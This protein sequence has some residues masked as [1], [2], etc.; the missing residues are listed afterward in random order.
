MSQKKHWDWDDHWDV[1]NRIWCVKK[2]FSD[3][4]RVPCAVCSILYVGDPI[5]KRDWRR[6]WN[7]Y[8]PFLTKWYL[9]CLNQKR[10]H[11]SLCNIL[12]LMALPQWLLWDQM[13]SLHL[14]RN[15]LPHR[16]RCIILR[17][18]KVRFV[19]MWRRDVY[20]YHH[21]RSGGYICF[22]ASWLQV[23]EFT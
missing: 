8:I 15:E 7:N 14:P 3:L 5:L 19:G 1:A 2:G 18:F 23:R 21:S 11:R 9:Q 10:R 22:H 17:H 4:L 6:L 16:L 20:R 13:P 12:V